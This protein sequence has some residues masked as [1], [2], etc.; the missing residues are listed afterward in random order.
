MAEGKD[1]LRALL[2]AGWSETSYERDRAYLDAAGHFQGRPPDAVFR[3][4]R[5]RTT[6]RVELSIWLAPVRVSGTPLWAGQLRHAI[7]R[8]FEIG[9]R[10]FGVNLDPDTSDGRNYVL[11]DLWYAQSLQHWA[12]SES[13]ID[14]PIAAPVSDF[15]GKPWFTRDPYRLALWISGRPIAL[16]Q[17]TPIVWADV[18]SQRGAR[19]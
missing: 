6:E 5:D 19:P 2:R 3:K 11:Q 15:N 18:E 8:R 14:V 9:E 16:P 1:L 12:W 13:G 4:G 17:A 7:G 10:F